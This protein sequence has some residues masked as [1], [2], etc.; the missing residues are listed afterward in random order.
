MSNPVGISAW[1]HES[2]NL[3]GSVS[4]IIPTYNRAELLREAIASVQS[5]TVPVRE[6]VV[7]DDGSTDETAEAV[8][9]LQDVDGRIIFVSATPREQASSERHNRCSAARNRGVAASSSSLLAFLDSDDLWEPDRVEKQLRSLSEMGDAGFAFCNLR[10][11]SADGEVSAPF[12]DVHTDYGGWILEDLLK[13]PLVVSSTLMVKRDALCAIGGWS[14]TAGMVEDY[15]LTL[16]LAARYK[17]AYTPDVLVCMRQ[18]EG[19]VSMAHAQ[20][21]HTGYLDVVAAFLDSHPKLPGKARAMARQGMANVHFK[22]ARHYMSLGDGQAARR[23]LLATL[24]RRPW[25][26]RALPAYFRSFLV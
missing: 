9:S 5:Q 15:E 3:D 24:V 21:T 22:L 14:E 19:R 11:F 7:A 16:R 17:A 20:E 18:H 13:E 1:P 10:L 6:I 8:R 2:G 26:R 23:H 25:D 12:L 4:V